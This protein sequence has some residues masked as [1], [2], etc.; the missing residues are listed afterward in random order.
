MTLQFS[1]L[2]NR[3]L[4]LN[5]GGKFK[6]L[7]NV[8]PH[9][10]CSFGCCIWTACSGGWHPAHGRGWDGMGFKVHSNPNHRVVL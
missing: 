8:L 3:A 9:C 10:L 4:Q 7:E 5:P 2:W 6:G 1:P